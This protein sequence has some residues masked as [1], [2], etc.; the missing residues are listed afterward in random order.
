[1]NGSVP[2]PKETV[3]TRWQADLWAR[4][5]YSFVSVGFSGSDYDLLAAPVIPPNPNDS[6]PHQELSELPRLFFAGEHT[7]LLT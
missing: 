2:L 6:N 7:Y 3:V 5:S 1:M 4:G